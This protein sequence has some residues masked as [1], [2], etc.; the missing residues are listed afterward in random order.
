MV[1]MNVSGAS[2]SPFQPIQASQLN[3]TDNRHENQLEHKKSI[4]FI[5]FHATSMLSC[6]TSNQAGNH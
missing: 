4:M 5:V 2:A 6:I 1:H 3:L